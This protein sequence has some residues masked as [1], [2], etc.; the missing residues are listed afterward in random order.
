MKSH[1]VITAEEAIANESIDGFI[2][3]IYENERPI[4]GLAARVDF[5]T[6]GAISKMVRNDV[7]TGH[8]GECAYLPYRREDID[9]AKPTY[10]FL[11][12]G[13]GKNSRPGERKSLP[14]KSLE[15]LQKNIVKLGWKKVGLSASD[16][17]ENSEAIQKTLSKSGGIEV[18]I[19]Q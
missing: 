5:K 2:I 14:E 13:G 10:R 4:Q 16:L 6:R 7:L 11:L 12:V 1:D 19:T 18:W 17:P 8:A 15:V 3:T 9:P